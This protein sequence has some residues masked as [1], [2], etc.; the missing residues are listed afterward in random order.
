VDPREPELTPGTRVGDRYEI[1]RRLAD[2]TYEALDTSTHKRV[3]LDTA[4]VRADSASRFLREA[5]AAARIRHPHV[6]AITGLGTD[7][8]RAYVASELVDGET[9]AAFVAREKRL[10]VDRTVELVLP[11]VAGVGAG[12][13]A[14]VIHGHLGPTSV[15]LTRELAPKVKDFGISLF[16]NPAYM[17]PEQALGHRYVD[18]RCDL[19]G[20]GLILYECVTGRPAH[21]GESPTEVVDSIAAGRFDPPRQVRGD[22]SVTFE[23]V[24][25]R[26][27]AQSPADRFPSAQALGA[28]LMP[29]GT[30]RAKAAWAE[31]FGAAPPSGIEPAWRP[32]SPSQPA[33]PVPVEAAPDEAPQLARRRA[34]L[35]VLALTAA[36]VVGTGIFLLR[37]RRAAK[38]AAPAPTFERK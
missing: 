15:F 3:A 14:G 29:F 26:A 11:V 28:A 6:V 13:A 2:R 25:M 20:L 30:R 27:L 7:G 17:S 35:G 10:A 24:V 8:D 4:I 38:I 36:I 16:A 9:L 31:T 21:V 1:V 19:Y 5:E 33:I 12:H 32:P 18:A 22:I 34:R 37:E 23:A